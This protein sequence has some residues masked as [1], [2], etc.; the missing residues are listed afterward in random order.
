[1]QANESISETT[2]SI[3]GEETKNR[4]GKGWY[5]NYEE[6]RYSFCESDSE[7][8]EREAAG[9]LMDAS[10]AFDKT[11]RNEMAAAVRVIQRTIE[12]ARAKS[13]SPQQTLGE[14]LTEKV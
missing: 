1:M 12:S 10:D 13:T 7:S 9:T 6:D 5:Y 3:D 4:M 14:V 2:S 11:A 8:P